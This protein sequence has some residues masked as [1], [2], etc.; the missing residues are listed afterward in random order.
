MSVFKH[1]YVLNVKTHNYK[2]FFI[3]QLFFVRY[4][5]LTQTKTIRGFPNGLA[6]FEMYILLYH[7]HQ[8]SV[9]SQDKDITVI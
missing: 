7:H 8:K 1:C 3:S 9:T 2:V 5:L 4:N 6:A